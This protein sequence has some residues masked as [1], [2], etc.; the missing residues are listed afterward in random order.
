MAKEV[1]LEELFDG[2]ALDGADEAVADYLHGL[3]STYLEE[4]CLEG[5]AIEVQTASKS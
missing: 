1:R 5:E 3:L 2:E 4:G